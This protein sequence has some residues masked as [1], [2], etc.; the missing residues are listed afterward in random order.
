MSEPEGPAVVILAPGVVV[1]RGS[2]LVDVARALAAA[3]SVVERR[4]GLVPHG[5]LVRLKMIMDAEARHVSACPQSDS[6]EQGPLENW[7]TTEGAAFLLGVGERHARRL[8][9]DLGGRRVAGRWRLPRS[10]V[11]A[12]SRERRT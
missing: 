3:I 9:K 5:K 12:A 7:V 6:P 1:L 2:A 11:E 8:A 4:D 10:N